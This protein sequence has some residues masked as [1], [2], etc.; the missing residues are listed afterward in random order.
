MFFLSK[1]KIG[2]CLKLVIVFR[3]V[4]QYIKHFKD[5]SVSLFLGDLNH[6]HI[7]TV[8]PF[9]KCLFKLNCPRFFGNKI[10]YAATNVKC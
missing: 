10:F 4:F 2:T 6:F 7:N 1:E 9:G 8:F 5:C 3:C